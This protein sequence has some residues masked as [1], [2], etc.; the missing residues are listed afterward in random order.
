MSDI[1]ANSTTTLQDAMHSN[2]QW[3]AV[4]QNLKDWFFNIAIDLV[5]KNPDAGSAALMIVIGYFELIGKF[6]INR[7]DMENFREGFNSVFPENKNN[8]NEKQ[9]CTIIYSDLR[10]G[11]YHWLSVDKRILL[12]LKYEEAFKCDAH[13]LYINPKTMIQRMQEHLEAFFDKL[14]R[15][16]N[17]S[18]AQQDKFT[19]LLGKQ[20]QSEVSTSFNTYAN[21]DHSNATCCGFLRF[22]S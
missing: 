6:K 2:N 12:S 9:I 15:D 19:N 5:N 3:I 4:K 14:I 21:I 18:K 17:A 22:L 20:P 10:C 11:L 16:H 1:W 7:N 13:V 8:S